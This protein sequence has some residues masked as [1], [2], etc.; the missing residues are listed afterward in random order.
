MTNK[1]ARETIRQYGMSLRDD[2]NIAIAAYAVKK[3]K[4]KIEF[5][6]ENKAVLIAEL[7]KIAAEKKAEA[8]KAEADKRQELEDLKSGKKLIKVVWEDGEYLQAY[9]VYGQ[10]A[11]LLEGL[12]LCHPVSGWGYCV[13]DKAVETL[14]EEFS[15]LDAVAYAQ[16]AIEEKAA[17]EKAAE[18]KEEN[19]KTGIFAEAKETGKP[20]VLHAWSEDCN[21]PHEE[22]NL[23]MVTVWANPDGTTKITRVHT[24]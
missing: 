4:S 5:F 17:K 6:R 21:D 14:G 22:C 18:E 12:G 20:Q 16:P 8:E 10:A 13:D 7:E 2:G 11:D 9:A 1:E 19:R 23:D 15:Y 24:W 3:A